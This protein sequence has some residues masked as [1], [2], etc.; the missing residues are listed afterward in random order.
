MIAGVIIVAILTAID[1][2][3]NITS[4][5]REWGEFRM[6]VYFTETGYID[7]LE[8]RLERKDTAIKTLVALIQ[9]IVDRYKIPFEKDLPSIYLSALKRE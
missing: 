4:I 8:E 2:T 3:L 5:E 9:E 1:M 6:K 7:S